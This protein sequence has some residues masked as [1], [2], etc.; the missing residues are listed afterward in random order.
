M[1]HGAQCGVPD[2]EHPWVGV[3]NP[4]AGKVGQRLLLHQVTRRIRSDIM[5]KM[6]QTCLHWRCIA[7]CSQ[8][9]LICFMSRIF[10]LSSNIHTGTN[11]WLFHLWPRL[12]WSSH[13]GLD[14]EL[15]GQSVPWYCRG[16]RAGGAGGIGGVGGARLTFTEVFYPSPDELASGAGGAAGQSP[17]PTAAQWSSCHGDAPR[18]GEGQVGGPPREGCKRGWT[19]M[20]SLSTRIFRYIWIQ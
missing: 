11:C 8:S 20:P 14:H 3:R 13:H 7:C 2:M 4:T 6:L 10:W 1:R 12:W 19:R 9:Y 17:I 18:S 15:C 16:G 5:M